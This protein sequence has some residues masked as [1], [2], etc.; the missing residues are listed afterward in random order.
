MGVRK[1]LFFFCIITEQQDVF[2]HHRYIQASCSPYVYSRRKVPITAQTV[3]EIVRHIRK[4]LAANTL[5][6]FTGIV[7]LACLTVSVHSPMLIN[8]SAFRNIF[9]TFFEEMDFFSQYFFTS[10]AV[11]E[12]FLILSN[13]SLQWLAGYVKLSRFCF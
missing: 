10:L 9:A 5:G 13:L 1:R 6:P 7:T 3:G 12:T 4:K 8:F 2:L 11:T